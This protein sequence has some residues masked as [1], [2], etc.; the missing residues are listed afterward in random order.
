MKT[1]KNKRKNCVAS[2][3]GRLVGRFFIWFGVT[4]LILLIG[5]Y[6]F[7]YFVNKGPSKRI[8][9]LFVASAKESSV[10]GVMADIYLSKE[11]IDEIL[12]KNNTSEFEEIT[13][14]AMIKTRTSENEGEVSE[15]INTEADQDPSI[16]PDGDGID[17][18]DVHGDT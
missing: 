2:R 14:I 13:D 4:F 17:I 10:G 15:E 1:T 11:E 12:A 3:I 7:L 16:D 9:D 5:S 18:F 6:I 8:R